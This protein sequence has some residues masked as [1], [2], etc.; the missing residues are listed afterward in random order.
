M[1]DLNSSA[2]KTNRMD[3]GLKATKKDIKNI[4]Q[5]AQHPPAT[6]VLSELITD[7]LQFLRHQ[8][9]SSELTLKA[10]S[11]DLSQAFTKKNEINANDLLTHARQAQS[12]WGKL[13]MSSRNRK[14]ATLKSFFRWLYD[15]NYIVKPVGELL[16]GPKVPKKIPDFISVDEILSILHLYENLKPVDE[17]NTVLQAKELVLFLLLYGGGL[18]IS[19]A[20]TAKWN[21]LNFQSRSLRITGKGNKERIVIL[22]KICFSKIERLKELTEESTY[23]FGVTELNSRTGYEWIRQMGK[24]ANLMNPLHPHSLRH[25]YATHMLASG[26]NLRTLQKLLGHDSLQATEKYTHLN[27]DQLARTLESKHPLSK[28]RPK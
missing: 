11:L 28:P 3:Y 7:F 24:K 15:R 14:T 20:C 9:S 6:L 19:E 2:P 22:P 26:A 10:Y 1:I 13:S 16:I 17:K 25:S 18:R 8:K 21:D 23:I 4:K 27:V 12:G 5:N